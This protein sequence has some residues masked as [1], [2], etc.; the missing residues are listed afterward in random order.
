MKI[1]LATA[2]FVIGTLLSPLAVHAED[3]DAD[4]AHPKEWVKDSV[5]T[6]KIKT[7][8]AADHPGSLKNISVDTD[9]SGVVWLT[10]TAKSQEEINQ[11]VATARG[12]KGVK[13]VWSDLTVKPA[14]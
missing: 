14:R 4:R 1:K 8:L 6:T 2:C 7:R 12:T 3:S 13:S 11:A 5:I 10:G 9:K